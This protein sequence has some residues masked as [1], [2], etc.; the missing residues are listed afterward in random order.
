MG[1]R[2]NGEGYRVD[3]GLALT[4]VTRDP[5]WLKKVLIGGVILLVSIPLSV[6]LVGL[7]GL[8]VFYGYTIAITRNVI[9]GVENPLPEWTDFGAYLSDGLKAWVGAL[10]WSLPL[11]VLSI[12]NQ[13]LG[14]ISDSTLIVSYFVG[15]CL[16]LPL[17]L[18]LGIFI[19]PTVVGRYADTKEIGAMLQFSE[20]IAQIRS[21]GVVP[22]LLL[23]VMAL[24]A[25]FVALF[26]VIAC[27][28]G[29]FFTMTW[30]LFAQAHG[31]GQVYRLRDGGAT[32][33]A[34]ADHPAF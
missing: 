7:L 12:C 18:L 24:I 27:V 9:N 10:V 1:V 34:P 13:I 6:I 20:V 28:I 3:I 19:T 15:F 31:I 26:G 22:Y 21:I 14:A 16:V 8:F 11:I 23:F 2:R 17:N 32:Y 25:G 29:I 4:Y 30:A 5:D 33:S